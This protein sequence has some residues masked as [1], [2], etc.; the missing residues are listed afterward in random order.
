MMKPSEYIL[1]VIHPI[2][3]KNSTN[4]MKDEKSGVPFKPEIQ[5]KCG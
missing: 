5:F 4:D 1:T 3:L 2:F